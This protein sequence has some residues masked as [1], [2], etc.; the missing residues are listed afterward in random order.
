ME[1]FRNM[2]IRNKF[3]TA[4]GALILCCLV[5]VGGIFYYSMRSLTEESI[6]RELTGSTS[7]ILTLVESSALSSTKNYLRAVAESNLDIVEVLYESFRR[8]EITEAEAK[9][10]AAEMLLSQKIGRTGYIYCVNSDGVVVV[11]PK[12]GVLG[13]NVSSYEFVR[14][15]I[16]GKLGYVEY[17]WRNPGENE[18][19]PKALY[20]TYFEPWDWIISTTS[21]RAEF[22]ELVDVRDIRKSVSSLRFGKSGYPYVIDG[23]G[24][25]LIHPEHEGANVKDL[26]SETGGFYDEMAKA[27]SGKIVYWW[28]NINDDKPRKKL[29]IYNTIPGFNWIVAS[30]YYFDELY[31]PL[32]FLKWF[33]AGAVVISFALALSLTSYIASSITGP[34]IRLKSSLKSG[35]DGDFSARVE[36]EGV[37]EV[38]EISRYFN[39]F[40]EKLEEY[41]RS[42]LRSKEIFS[43]AFHSS[44]NALAIVS[45]SGGRIIDVNPSFSRMSGF[46]SEEAAGA[47]LA[48]LGVFGN[49]GVELGPPAAADSGRETVIHLRGGSERLGQVFT[50]RILIGEEDCILLTVVDQTER[51]RLERELLKI[52]DR[53]KRNIAQYL[54]DDLLPHLIGIEALAKVM[55]GRLNADGHEAAGTGGMIDGLV[56][57]AIQKARA[58]T[59][60]LSSVTLS[61][62]GVEF[63][64]ADLANQTKTVFAVDCSLEV[65][66][67]LPEISEETASNLYYIAKE[68]VHNA[69]K[70][71]KCKRIEISVEAG[72]QG[73]DALILQVSDDGSGFDPE[74]ALKGMGLR[75][76]AWRANIIGAHLEVASRTGEGAV[77]TLRL[78]GIHN[79]QRS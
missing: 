69:V 49:G 35:A 11:H 26:M 23:N 21:Y 48:G 34:L 76:M 60:G 16:K 30:S 20:M 6:E 64:L 70:H 27:R 47:T 5:A 61:D 74:A 50:E 28:K 67:D 68:A 65:F 4:Y 46:S 38:G 72:G 2:K 31:A 24:K 78:P 1:P 57:D 37:D 36:A 59:R 51:R 42:L 53:E 18:L 52:A 75:I 19:K 79:G 9:K 29:V 17:R 73:D 56:K 43:K 40:M 7:S 45:M 13:Q 39:I 10:R 66:G 8:G 25:L 15:Q 14:D 55:A 22:D 71:S 33:F 62:R 41:N 3:I 63:A 77:V 44:P 58:I 54:H 12:P 32:D